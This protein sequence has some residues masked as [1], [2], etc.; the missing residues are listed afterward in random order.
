MWGVFEK[1][2]GGSMHLFASKSVSTSKACHWLDQLIYDTA[3]VAAR[4]LT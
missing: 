1:R 3:M 2:E 4:D